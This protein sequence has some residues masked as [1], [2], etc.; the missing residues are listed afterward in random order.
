MA[1]NRPCRG[2][3]RARRAGTAA[4]ASRHTPVRFTS[5]CT[6]QASSVVRHASGPPTSTPAA[7]TAASRPPN[8]SVAAATAAAIAAP[9]RTSATNPTTSGPHRPRPRRARPACPGHRALP[10]RRRRRRPRPR[11]NRRRPA[12]GPSPRR[13][14][15]AAP[16]TRAT[17]APLTGYAATN[18]RWRRRDRR[19]SPRAA[20][21]P[22]R[23]WHPPDR[24]ARRWATPLSRHR[25]A[26]W[27]AGRRAARCCRPRRGRA[28]RSRERWPAAAT[29]RC[30][31]RGRRPPAPGPA[32]AE[33][34]GPRGPG[35]RTARASGSALPPWPDTTTTPP[36]RV[37]RSHQLH[38]DLLDRGLP[39]RQGAGESR[40]AH[41]SIRT[42]TRRRDHGRPPAAGPRPRPPR[43]RS[44]CRCRAAGGDRAAR[45]C[46]AGRT[47][48]RAGAER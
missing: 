9:D 23:R 7:A 41:R 37:G 2:S 36:K 24:R 8:R 13:C 38:D 17:P 34:A 33:R 29:S 45:C 27:A 43:P 32:R 3:G 42:A 22:R 6:V 39:D 47:S 12:G 35:D 14:P 18:A 1:T 11:P 44:G 46:P 10:G 16:V 25:P 48:S 26:G 40:R 5:I 19:P 20:L 28:G 15:R 4:T 31:R 30:G 21:V